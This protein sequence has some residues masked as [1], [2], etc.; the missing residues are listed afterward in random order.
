[1]SLPPRRAI[2]VAGM[3]RSGT[4][5]ATRVF[6]LLGADLPGNLFPSTEENETGYWESR[7]VAALNDSILRSLGT[8]W[9]DDAPIDSQWFQGS[10]AAVFRDE[11]YQFFPPRARPAFHEA[12]LAELV[13]G[14]D[15]VVSSRGRQ[16]PRGVKR[17]MSKFPLRP[18]CRR[19]ACVRCVRVRIKK[20]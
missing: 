5:A 8:A 18:R 2:L 4:S 15:R 12:L 9:H 19:R 11:I 17:K 6:N 7:D 14:R 20:R 13:D 10:A 1:M 16:V 3:H